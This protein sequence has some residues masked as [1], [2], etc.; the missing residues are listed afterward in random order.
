LAD[1][2]EVRARFRDAAYAAEYDRTRFGGL[3]G[4]IKNYTALRLLQRCLD[5]VRPAGPV[6]DLP[7]GTG[8][9]ASVLRERGVRAV[10]VDQSL[11]ML[12]HAR[13][14]GAETLVAAR[15]EELPFRDGAL[16]GVVS[17]R[18]FHYL[19]GDLRVRMLAEMSRVT[20]RFAILEFRYRNRVRGA[21]RAAGRIVGMHGRPKRYPALSQI[22]RE[23]AG[24]GFEVVRVRFRPRLASDTCV[25]IARK[26]GGA[27]PPPHTTRRSP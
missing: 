13:A 12:A 14:K 15:A 20:R 25:V 27:P 9:L 11:A 6:L 21:L 4:G 1:Y 24:A 7:C 19:P 5:E 26:P 2:G 16:D 18:F 17:L 3:F 23:V 8:R 22:L 10:G